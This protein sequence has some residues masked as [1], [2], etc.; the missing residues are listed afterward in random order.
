MSPFAE[1]RR[2]QK[3]GTVTIGQ[4]TRPKRATPEPTR[5][6]CDRGLKLFVTASL[7]EPAGTKGLS[8]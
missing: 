6:G 1:I 5:P 7:L 8:H 2:D 4:V 3:S